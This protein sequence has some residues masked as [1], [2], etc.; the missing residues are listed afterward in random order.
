M[1]LNLQEFV[2][3]HLELEKYKEAKKGMSIVAFFSEKDKEQIR[4]S[5]ISK[6]KELNNTF[7]S[8]DNLH[9]TFLSIYPSKNIVQENSNPYFNDLIITNLRQFFGKKPN[10]TALT[11]NFD[12]F[13]PGTWHGFNH[14]QI[15]DA[16]DGTVVA[17]GD[18]HENGNEKFVNLAYQLVCHLKNKLRPIFN[19]EFDR[20]F[21]TVWSTL[22]YFDCIDFGITKEFANKFNQINKLCN[23]IKI[24]IDLLHLVEYS[25]KD[26]KRLN[27]L[28]TYRL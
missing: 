20:K 4:N 8:P 17:M 21:P 27:I 16:S 24:E 19:D 23:N 14:M 22:G 13:R 7:V 6:I 12:E 26:L 15:P 5:V 9:T 1:I 11:L 3:I 28:D 18:P 10:N 2:P 25:F